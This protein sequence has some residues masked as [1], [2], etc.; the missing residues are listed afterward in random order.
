M[1]AT[2]EIEESNFCLCLKTQL[3]MLLAG[4]GCSLALQASSPG[5][6]EWWQCH[7]DSGG[8]IG[9]FVGQFGSSATRSTVVHSGCSGFG[10]AIPGGI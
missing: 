2:F 3:W 6:S 8:I 7:L 9:S 1:F 5:A 10:T 4:K